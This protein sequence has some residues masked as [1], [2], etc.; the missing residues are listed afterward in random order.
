MTVVHVVVVVLAAAANLFSAAADFARAERI[1]SSM[2]R[3]GVPAWSLPWLGVPKAVAV[4]GLLAGLARPW[5]GVAAAAG[6]VVFFAL[7]IGTHLRAGD[8]MVGLPAGFLLLA[9]A[10]LVTA[11][12]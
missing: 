12:G 9:V 10:V 4:V 8:R 3:I 2:W 6:L 11:P 7:A 5:A 1:R